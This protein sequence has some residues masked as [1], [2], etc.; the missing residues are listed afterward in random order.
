MLLTAGTVVFVSQVENYKIAADNAKTQLAAAQATQLQAQRDAEQARQL[1]SDARTAA[2]AQATA[3]QTALNAAQQQIADRDAQIAQLSA[4]NTLQ[5]ADANRLTEALKAS[6]D[7]KSRQAEQLAD[8]RTKFDQR[9]TQNAQLNASVSDLTNRLDVTERERRLLAEQVAELQSQNQKLGGILKDNNINPNDVVAG[10]LRRGAPP[11]NGVIR[12][13][14]KI[15]GMDYAT[16]S[17]GSADNVAKGMEFKVIDR[18]SGNFLGTLT[19]DSVE[20]NESTG[21]L[22]GPRVADVHPGTEVRTQL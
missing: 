12:D 16:I 22:S 11:I 4:A 20:A 5:I 21:R 8:M 18:D 13:V 10:G 1:A 6:E 9:V 17:V 15:A 7:Q 14:R 19:V 2:L 3:S